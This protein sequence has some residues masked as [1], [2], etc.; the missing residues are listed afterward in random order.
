MR[1]WQG[2]APSS[3]KK[4]SSVTFVPNSNGSNAIVAWDQ[5]RNEINACDLQAKKSSD[6][7]NVGV[8]FMRRVTCTGTSTLHSDCRAREMAASTASGAAVKNMGGGQAGIMQTDFRRY[9]TALRARVRG[10][11]GVHASGRPTESSAEAVK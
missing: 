8:R 2:C 10:G 5:R 7:E 11:A 3:S 6:M 1:L 9:K 4:T